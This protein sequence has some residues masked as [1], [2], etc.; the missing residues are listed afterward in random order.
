MV[1]ILLGPPGVGKGTQA[2][3][4]AQGLGWTHVSTGDLL[5]AA[6]RQG[7][8][9]GEKARGYMDAGELVPDDL[10]LAMVQEHLASLPRES[11]VVLDGFPRTV[12]QALM[13]EAVCPDDAEIVIEIFIDDAVV[14]KRL[15]ARINCSECGHIHNLLVNPPKKEGLCDLCGGKLDV[16]SDDRKDVIKDRLA[17]Y[18]AEHKALVKHYQ[19]KEVY[20]SVDGDAGIP[21]VFE[22]ISAF[23]DEKMAIWR[24]MKVIQ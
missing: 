11:G 9:L 2:V 14:L 20:S 12:Q 6:R 24:Q 16:R 8:E 13:F 1:V 21:S 19:E 15:T 22:G 3:L 4:L 7:T 18:H 23:I 10:I 17:V 5:R